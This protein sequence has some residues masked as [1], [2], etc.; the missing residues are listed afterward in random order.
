MYPFHIWL[1]EAH[2]E[3]PTSGSMILA[4]LLLKLGGYGFLRFSIALFPFASNYYSSFIYV[5]AVISV[6]YASCCALVQI[7]FKKL[8]AYSSIAHMNMAVL[9]IFSNNFFGL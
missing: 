8:I 4:G 6:I 9:G 1:P 5:I 3:A 2:V 7:D